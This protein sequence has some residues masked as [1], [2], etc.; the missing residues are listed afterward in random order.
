MNPKYKKFFNSFKK[1]GA[2]SV[3]SIMVQTYWNIGKMIVEDEQ[4]GETKAMYGK[5][6]LN[7]SQKHLPMSLIKVL[8]LEICEI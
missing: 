6:S 7:L 3:N 1:L 2:T 5:K 8:L 4:K